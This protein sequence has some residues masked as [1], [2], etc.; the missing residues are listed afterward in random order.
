MD[1]TTPTAGPAVTVWMTRAEAAAA[2][3]ISERQI[4][5]LIAAGTLTKYA[6]GV[7]RYSTALLR[8]QVEALAAPA[9]VDGGR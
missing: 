2:L 6:R 1:P 3:G 5:R 7:G 8:S 4:D 9:A